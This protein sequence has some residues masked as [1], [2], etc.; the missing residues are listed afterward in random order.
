MSQITINKAE[1]TGKQ[2]LPVFR[3]VAKRFD[4][5]K[6][7]AF[8]LFQ[9]RGH[10][11]GRELEDWLQAEREI[12]GWPAAELAEKE[13]AYEVQVALPGFDAKE[14]EVTT[15]PTELVIH[16][17]TRHEAKGKEKDVV[18]SEFGSNDVYRRFDLPSKIQIEKVAANLDKGILKVTAPFADRRS[19]AAA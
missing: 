4:A 14:V 16:A 9:T 1:E 10:G 15:T 17:A 11:A 18:W 7:R 6:Q 8:E 3:E 5:I 19:A 13:N 12:L 2:T